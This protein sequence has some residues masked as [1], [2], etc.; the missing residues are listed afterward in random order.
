MLGIHEYLTLI[1]LLLNIFLH[2][3]FKCLFFKQCKSLLILD[4]TD[5]LSGGLNLPYAAFN[6]LILFCCYLLY[7]FLFLYIRLTFPIIISNISFIEDISDNLF[8]TDYGNCLIL[9]GATLGFET[10]VGCYIISLRKE[11]YVLSLKFN[12]TFK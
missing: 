9:F 6:I 8:S 4:F 12:F 2:F 11:R 10:I 3:L 1:M 5:L 7:N